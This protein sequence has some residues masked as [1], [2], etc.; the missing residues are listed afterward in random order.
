MTISFFSLV[1]GDGDRVY[2]ILVFWP[3]DNR[4]MTVTMSMSERYIPRNE[5]RLWIE[6]VA[7]DA[8]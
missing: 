8:I 4:T 7:L 6:W 2:T 1:L 5:N 3:W